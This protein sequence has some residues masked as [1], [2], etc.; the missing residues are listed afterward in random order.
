MSKD[1][2]LCMSVLSA[3]LAMRKARERDA[4]SSWDEIAL[5]LSERGMFSLDFS[6]AIAIDRELNWL[7]CP[8]R[9]ESRVVQFRDLLGD[10][11]KKTKP[12]WLD[13]VPSGLRSVKGAINDDVNQVL[14]SA[15]L[16]GEEIDRDAIA[17]WDQ[18]ASS[19]RK[20]TDDRLLLQGRNAEELSFNFECAL[21]KRQGIESHVPKWVSIE[22]NSL[23]YDILSFRLSADGDIRETLIEVKSTSRPHP[24]FF[25]SRNEWKRA[26]SSINHYQF[27]IWTAG[28]KSPLELPAHQIAEHVPNDHGK[29]KWQNVLVDLAN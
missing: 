17:W 11:L 22:D 19:V 5:L 7:S 12:I 27:H 20:D 25:I 13:A 23:G 3:V 16:L 24:Y 15:G 14:E 8:I 29:G 4:I 28:S 10:I 2:V 6:R 18:I 9:T 1:S 26:Q 21:L